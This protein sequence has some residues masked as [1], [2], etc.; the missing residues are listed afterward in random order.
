MATPQLHLTAQ[1][2]Q[3]NFPELRNARE[4]ARGG[5]K[6]VFSADHPV[7]GSVVLKVIYPTQGLEAVRREILAV[8]QINSPRVPRILEHGQAPTHLGECYWIREVRVIGRSVRDVLAAGPVSPR[9]V[10]RLGR[11]VLEAI[12]RAEANRIV[13][14]DIKPDNVMVDGEGAFWLLDFGIARH[15]TLLS[16]TATGLLFGKMTLGYAPPEQCRNLKREI[17]QRADLFA[18]GVTMIE[19]AT[20]RHPFRHGARDDLDIVR[21]VESDVLPPCNLQVREQR[22]LSDLVA[23]MTQ[24]R[25]DHRPRTAQDALNWLEQICRSEGI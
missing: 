8:Q 10:L 25:R 17:D 21:R 18:L 22:Q 24:K 14:R 7:D 4:L 20:G 19:C 9:D 5:Q 13:H 23:A 1:W 2:L 15:L 16:Q 12:V 11:N 6:I 3:Q